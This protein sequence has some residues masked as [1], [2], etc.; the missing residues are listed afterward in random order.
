MPF[1]FRKAAGTAASSKRSGGWNADPWGA[2]VRRWYDS[3]DGWT[4]RVERA[5]L[6]P[7]KTGVARLDEANAS[8]NAPTAVPDP[9]R[10]K[11]HRATANYTTT[12][13]P[14]RAELASIGQRLVADQVQ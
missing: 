8:F 11:A 6:E 14:L 3:V 5:G 7:D 1:M 2:A 9:V 13:G 10:S 12:G 4:D